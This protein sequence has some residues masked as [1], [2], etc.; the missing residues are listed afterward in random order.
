MKKVTILAAITM[1]SVLLMAGLV[2]AQEKMATPAEAR[3][4]TKKI[5]AYTKQVGCEK[6]FAEF[7][8]TKSHW[9]TT[10]KNAYAS[11]G[12]WN[13]IVLAQGKY[14]ALVGQNHMEA[15]DA[16]GTLFTKL[17]IEKCKKTGKAEQEFKWMI[18]Q[19][20]KIESRTLIVEVVDCG[21][22]K[23]DVGITYGGK[24]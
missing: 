7:N 6:A 5:V 21:G 17:A 9:N 13:G 10:Y 2:Q 14:P 22:K 15:K 11:A 19:T 4:W 18:S 20:N 23:V 3:E 24:L 1:V 16:E 12:D 8:D